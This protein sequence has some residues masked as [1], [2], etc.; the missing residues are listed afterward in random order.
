M[1]GDA[2]RRRSHSAPGGISSIIVMNDTKNRGHALAERRGKAELSRAQ[3]ADLVGCS[4]STLGAIEQGAVPA[5]SNVL[6]RA[7]AA[8]DRIEAAAGDPA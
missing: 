4:I 3:L 5:R 2:G 1:R 6:D 7:E 8:L